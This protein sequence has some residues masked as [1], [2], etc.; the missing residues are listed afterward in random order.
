MFVGMGDG[1][2][3]E[4]RQEFN[5]HIKQRT[6]LRIALRIVM[7]VLPGAPTGGRLLVNTALQTWASAE[8][9]CLSTPLL[10]TCASTEAAYWQN[11][12]YKD[13]TLPLITHHSSL[14]SSRLN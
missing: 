14:S 6:T 3:S 1:L 9:A 13:R 8:G 11:H 4:L 12:L 7:Q 5:V 10:Q 2:G